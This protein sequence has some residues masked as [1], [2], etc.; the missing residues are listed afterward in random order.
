[1]LSP[2]S[3]TRTINDSYPYAS[4]VAFGILKTTVFFAVVA[5]SSLLFAS[6]I[7]GAF[8]T[9]SEYLSAIALKTVSVEYVTLIKEKIE[10]L[11]Y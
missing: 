6:T 11:K 2:S 9:A 1:M 3:H 8:F 10:F 4:S 7:V 5:V